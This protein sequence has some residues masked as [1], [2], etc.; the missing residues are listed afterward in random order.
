MLGKQQGHLWLTEGIS[1]TE[2]TKFGPCMTTLF[3]GLIDVKYLIR[4]IGGKRVHNMI[5]GGILVSK[6]PEEG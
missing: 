5:E 1:L 2:E 4:L 6:K 3:P